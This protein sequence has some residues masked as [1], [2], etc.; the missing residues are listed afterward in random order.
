MSR[1]VSD[2]VLHVTGTGGVFTDWFYHW[3]LKHLG[4]PLHYHHLNNVKDKTQFIMWIEKNK[5]A[6][7]I[8]RKDDQFPAKAV[9]IDKDILFGKNPDPVSQKIRADIDLDAARLSFRQHLKFVH[10][11]CNESDWVNQYYHNDVQHSVQTL[12]DNVNETPQG[13]FAPGPG[14][15][16]LPLRPR[17]TT[18]LGEL[19]NQCYLE[20]AFNDTFRERGFGAIVLNKRYHHANNPRLQYVGRTPPRRAVPVKVN[21]PTDV[22]PSPINPDAYHMFGNQPAISEYHAAPKCLLNEYDSLHKYCPDQGGPFTSNV[23]QEDLENILF[24]YEATKQDWGHQTD[25]VPT[26]DYNFVK[27]NRSMKTSPGYPYN[28]TVENCAE[29]ISMFSKHIREYIEHSKFCWTPTIFTVFGKEEILKSSKGNE[30]RTIIAP[31]VANQIVA[32]LQ[33]LKLSKMVS[34]NYQKS[35]TQIGRTRFHGDVQRTAQRINR[36][37]QITEYDFKKYD[38]SIHAF[39]LHM[40]MIYLWDV[41]ADKTPENFNQLANVF[42]NTIYSFMQLR[43]GDVYRKSYGIPSGFTLT[44]YAN[45]WIH[46]FLNYFMYASLDPSGQPRD[47]NYLIKA[48]Q[49][50]DF[51]CYGDDGLMGHHNLSWFGPDARSTFLREVFNMYLPPETNRT[52][53]RF[54]VTKTPIG[55]DGITFLGDI[56]APTTQG[57][58]PIFS[59]QKAIATIVYGSYGRRFSN[60]DSLLIAFSHCVECFL[61]PD[62][63]ILVDW[64]LHC[65]SKPRDSISGISTETLQIVLADYKVM[66][67]LELLYTISKAPNVS[68][69]LRTMI[70]YNYYAEFSESPLPLPEVIYSEGSQV[71]ECPRLVVSERPYP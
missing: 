20:G 42:E 4:F 62:F 41:N 47:N 11:S 52:V 34:K 13:T 3:Y 50:F 22:I 37:P 31:C 29:A 36:F 54:F 39:L 24:A 49:D 43:N 40:F 67:F 71:S 33:T 58:Q 63:Q 26:A 25:S 55:I 23:N 53:Q 51:V 69:T 14:F 68:R 18:G 10:T 46:T 59:V 38:R 30:I 45:S 2:G 12:I 48:K 7:T 28:R 66:D 19:T 70:W 64:F 21:E 61:H 5:L 35:H 9:K 32:Q 1:L 57:F 60:V 6:H 8:W 16:F 15:G 56:I 17:D 65:A 44:S 27:Q